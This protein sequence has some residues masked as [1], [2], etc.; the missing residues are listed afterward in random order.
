MAP[1][2]ARRR[3]AKVAI[4]VAQASKAL[5]LI[6]LGMV[7]HVKINLVLLIGNGDENLSM[8]SVTNG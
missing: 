4:A 2:T 8:W 1:R 7:P 3:H 6:T 5:C